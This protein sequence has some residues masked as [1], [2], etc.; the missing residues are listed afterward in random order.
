MTYGLPGAHSLLS[1]RDSHG[2]SSSSEVERCV[3][4]VRRGRLLL[5]NCGYVTVNRGYVT[6]S[7]GDAIQKGP[8]SCGPFLLFV[9][10]RVEAGP[11][12]QNGYWHRVAFWS[13]AKALHRYAVFVIDEEGAGHHDR[14]QGL[15]LAPGLLSCIAFELRLNLTKSLRVS[16]EFALRAPCSASTKKI[17]GWLTGIQLTI[18]FHTSR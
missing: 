8:A 17:A 4:T 14:H 10:E 12:T 6:A 9:S 1:W 11:V 2:R 13:P 5:F 18:R 3:W 7:L 15:E 16:D